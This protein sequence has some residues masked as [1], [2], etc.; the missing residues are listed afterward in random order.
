MASSKDVPTTKP[1][2]FQSANRPQTSIDYDY[3]MGNLAHSHDVDPQPNS[4]TARHRLDASRRRIRQLQ[5]NTNRVHEAVAKKVWFERQLPF[6]YSAHTLLH[7]AAR[8][9]PRMSCHLEIW[10]PQFGHDN[11]HMHRG[12]QHTY[13]PHSGVCNRHCTAA[14]H[15]PAVLVGV[16]SH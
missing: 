8:H 14:Q 15:L 9:S 7:E 11:H 2:Q 4:H 12:K 16:L 5:P 10:N 3:R 6:V 1:Q 13:S